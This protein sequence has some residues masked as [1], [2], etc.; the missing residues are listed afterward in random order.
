M[1]WVAIGIGLLLSSL[2]T[3]KVH[4]KSGKFAYSVMKKGKEIGTHTFIVEKTKKSCV[5]TSVKEMKPEEGGRYRDST[6]FY[7]NKKDGTPLRADVWTD[8]LI[9]SF[10]PIKDYHDINFKDGLA[11][12]TAKLKFWP[13]CLIENHITR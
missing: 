1:Y 11:T 12:N 10:G 5:V 4:L 2:P 3:G 9:G 6:V 8:I 7:L 13:S